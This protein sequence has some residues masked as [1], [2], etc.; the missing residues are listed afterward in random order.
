MAAPLMRGLVD[1][2]SVV[3]GF[4]GWS[5][6]RSVKELGI[7]GMDLDALNAFLQ[8]GSLS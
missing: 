6:G 5:A 4:D 7:E 1:I 2:G 3:M 8:T